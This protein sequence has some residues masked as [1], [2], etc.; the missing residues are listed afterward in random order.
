MQRMCLAA[1]DRAVDFAREFIDGRKRS[2]VQL[3]IFTWWIFFVQQDFQKPSWVENVNISKLGNKEIAIW[4]SLDI[5][6]YHKRLT[7]QNHVNTISHYQRILTSCAIIIWLSFFRKAIGCTGRF[8]SGENI[9]NMVKVPIYSSVQYSGWEGSGTC[10]A[11]NKI[12]KGDPVYDIELNKVGHAFWKKGMP[13][14]H[15]RAYW[16]DH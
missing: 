13:C 9:T 12:K 5:P 1:N 8:F 7:R 11:E 2:K 10:Y 14:A 6:T 3:R 15:P 4:N 16:T